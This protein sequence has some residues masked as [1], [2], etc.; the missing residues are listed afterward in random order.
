MTVDMR[1]SFTYTLGHLTGNL[2]RIKERADWTCY[3]L[4]KSVL[5][6]SSQTLDSTAQLDFVSSEL[7]CNEDWPAPTGLFIGIK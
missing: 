5:F 2:S 1:F 4:C 6:S 3:M 7:L